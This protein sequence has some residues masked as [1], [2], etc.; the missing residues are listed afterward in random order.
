MIEKSKNYD[1]SLGICRGIFISKI[2]N[3]FGK[4]QNKY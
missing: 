1:Y 2:Q 3:N 4:I